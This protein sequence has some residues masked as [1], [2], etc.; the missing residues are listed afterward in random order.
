VILVGGLLM[1]RGAHIVLF[2]VINL[3]AA[4]VIL[5]SYV[6]WKRERSGAQSVAPHVHTRS[7]DLRCGQGHG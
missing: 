1:S 3:C 7:S 2:A 5:Y 4:S 6:E